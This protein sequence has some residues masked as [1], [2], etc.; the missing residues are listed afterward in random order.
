MRVVPPCTKASADVR[1]RGYAPNRVQLAG[2]QLEVAQIMASGLADKERGGS[3]CLNRFRAFL[4]WI[5]ALIMLRP[6]PATAG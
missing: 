4:K 2:R 6:E 3:V 1:G 5:P